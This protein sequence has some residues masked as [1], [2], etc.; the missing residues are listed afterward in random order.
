VVIGQGDL[1]VTFFK[2]PNPEV[3]TMLS[4]LHREEVMWVLS[5][6]IEPSHGGPFRLGEKLDDALCDITTAY[7]DAYNDINAV[8]EGD[9]YAE[10]VRAE[11][12]GDYMSDVE[13]GK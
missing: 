4:R 9:P 7:Q 5:E 13:R 6:I 1:N 3:L 11:R 12:Y 8:L 10:N 2:K